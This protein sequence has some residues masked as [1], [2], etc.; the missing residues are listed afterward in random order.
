MHELVYCFII[1]TLDRIVIFFFL[2]SGLAAI[3]ALFFIRIQHSSNPMS[4]L[5][6]P[7]GHLRRTLG[8]IAEIVGNALK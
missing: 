5:Y 2:F 6:L 1:S 7:H 3:L 8:L 4:N